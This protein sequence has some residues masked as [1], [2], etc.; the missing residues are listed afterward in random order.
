MTRLIDVKHLGE[1]QPSSLHFPKSIPDNIY[2]VWYNVRVTARRV[3][4]GVLKSLTSS[5]TLAVD[6]ALSHVSPGNRELLTGILNES[7]Y[8]QVVTY[9]D[10]IVAYSVRQVI[11]APELNS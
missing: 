9:I 10:V 8:P 2:L 5:E 6:K 7:S 1:D 3:L 11:K 4:A